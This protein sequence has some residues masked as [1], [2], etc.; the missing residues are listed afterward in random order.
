M[1]SSDLAA[2]GSGLGLPL[3][4]RILDLCGGRI[5]AQSA[6]GRGSSFTVSLPQGETNGTVL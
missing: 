6:P 1:C 3:V 4:R 2:E 5:T